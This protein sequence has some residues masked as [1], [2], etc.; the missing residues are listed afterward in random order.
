MITIYGWSTSGLYR[1]NGLGLSTVVGWWVLR[2]SDQSRW[3]GYSVAFMDRAAAF[4]DFL[5]TGG[6]GPD[7]RYV[8]HKDGQVSGEH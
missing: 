4:A 1:V 3:P 2:R 5:L 7:P 6:V 8:R